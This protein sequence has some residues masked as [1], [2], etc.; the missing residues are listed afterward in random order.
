MGPPWALEEEHIVP[1]TSVPRRLRAFL[2]PAMVWCASC[3]PG[4]IG[5]PPDEEVRPPGDDDDASSLDDDD[6]SSLD[7]DDATVDDG[8]PRL[9]FEPG[10]VR[11]G[12]LSVVFTTLHNV[13]LGDDAMVCC[14]DA[15][16]RY[17]RVVEQLNEQMLDLLFYFGLRAEGAAEWG[18]EV[19]G[20]QAIGTFEIEPLGAV[21][22]LLPGLAAGTAT[23][24]EPGDFDVLSFEVPEPNSLVSIQASGMADGM[25]PWIWVFEDDGMTSVMNAGLETAA[26][27]PDPAVG[28][29]VEE[30]GSYFL[31]VDENDDEA[32]G[33]DQI[34]DIDLL[35][36]P[37]GDAMDHDEVEPNDASDVW[38]DL[39]SMT[40]GIHHVSGVAATAGHDSNN[41][42]TGD[43]DVFWFQLWQPSYVEF[44]LTW[45]TDD[46]LDALLYRGTPAQVQLGFG[47]G[48]AISY[49][50][51]S[52]ERPESARLS[53]TTG[54]YVIEI[55]N[56]Q[57]DPDVP[58]AMDLRVVPMSF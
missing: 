40:P 42:L 52:A 55:G 20:D 23:V 57:G 8:T 35:I 15:N 26:G 7:D 6:A 12:D 14:A 46:D 4:G 41:D 44:E 17:Y 16:V 38:Q 33:D 21:P 3:T 36:E 10:V 11:A 1:R 49:G 25:H 43:L 13:E 30:P 19:D 28:F 39:G 45:Q 37:A 50:M 27:F 5:G 18:L 2:L 47:S 29:W 56:W 48:Q 51:A 34:C 58:W 24:S 53:L 22:E 9:T 54:T 32:G 31:R